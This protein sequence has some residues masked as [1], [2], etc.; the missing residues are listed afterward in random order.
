MGK[1]D[2]WLSLDC[3]VLSVPVVSISEWGRSC[4]YCRINR[5]NIWGR[6]LNGRR[7]RAFKWITSLYIHF[8]DDSK[9]FI[10]TDRGWI[11][12][13]QSSFARN[14]QLTER[15]GMKFRQ[16]VKTKHMLG[17]ILQCPYP[18]NWSVGG[19]LTWLHMIHEIILADFLSV[20][21]QL[22]GP[23]GW[24]TKKDGRPVFKPKGRNT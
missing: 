15:K 2:G 24:V 9:F 5:T 18:Q 13:L 12:I 16:Y 6:N 14:E 7:A 3:R 4:G 8:T 20:S 21:A 17:D 1:R 23:S 11:N 22:M 10:Q 19:Y